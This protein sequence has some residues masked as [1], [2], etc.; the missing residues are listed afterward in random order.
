MKA[1]VDV[2][3]MNSKT[4]KVIDTMVDVKQIKELNANFDGTTTIIFTHT[5]RNGN[6]VDAIVLLTVEEI[7]KRIVEAKIWAD[8][9]EARV[10]EGEE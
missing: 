5:Y 9:Y 4:K 1:F 3:W 7:E 6:V 10:A 2:P 8:G